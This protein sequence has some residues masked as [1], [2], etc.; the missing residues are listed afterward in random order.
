[1]SHANNDVTLQLLVCNKP[2]AQQILSHL[3][4]G[5]HQPP[6]AHQASQGTPAA[7]QQQAGDVHHAAVLLSLLL[8]SLVLQQW[9]Y[10]LLGQTPQL[11]PLTN[12]SNDSEPLCCCLCCP[13]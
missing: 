2:F 7:Q 4:S 3:R 13:F 1:M 9:R 6:Q 8:P 5:A 10:L 11:L 12:N